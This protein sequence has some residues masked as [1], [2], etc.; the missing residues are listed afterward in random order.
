MK[1]NVER[2]FVNLND[3]FHAASN[4]ESNAELIHNCMHAIISN[5]IK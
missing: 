5:D 4:L 2:L 3:R 1:R